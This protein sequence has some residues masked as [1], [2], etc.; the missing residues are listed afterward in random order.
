MRTV[1][2]YTKDGALF[3]PGSMF[4]F[5]ASLYCV[6]VYCAYLLP[7]R[8]SM[9]ISIFV[10]VFDFCSFSLKYTVIIIFICVTRVKTDA[11][12]RKV[13][14]RYTDTTSAPSENGDTSSTSGNEASVTATTP[15]L[16]E[17]L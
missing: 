10:R 15:L 11:D 7:V 16:Q 6:A 12:S 13:N 3:G 2:Q 9:P 5:A 14:H 17:I 4:L 8:S 1:Y